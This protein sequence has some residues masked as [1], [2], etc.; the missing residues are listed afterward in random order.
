MGLSFI[1]VSCSDNPTTEHELIYIKY[2]IPC[3][4]G[5]GVEK[6]YQD[7]EAQNLFKRYNPSKPFVYFNWMKSE[8]NKDLYWRE[9]IPL[10][11]SNEYLFNKR[12]EMYYLF[13]QMKF[14]YMQGFVIAS[15]KICIDEM[16]EELK[17]GS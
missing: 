8:E 10:I 4:Q 1:L 6:I 14:S 11:D 2:L 12:N 17:N 5:V 9:L 13:D 7:E 15:V 3:V 16:N